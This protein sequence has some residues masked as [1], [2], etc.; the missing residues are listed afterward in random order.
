MSTF[1]EKVPSS[2]VKVTSVTERIE[3]KSLILAQ[4]ERWR[5]A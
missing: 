1:L 5:H 4:I 3:L 2:K